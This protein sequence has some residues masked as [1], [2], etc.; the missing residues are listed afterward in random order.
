M[1]KLVDPRSP[2]KHSLQPLNSLSIEHRS[3]YTN[4]RLSVMPRPCNR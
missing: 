4:T 3:S 2:N 1:Q